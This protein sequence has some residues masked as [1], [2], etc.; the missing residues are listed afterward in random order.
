MSFHGD[1]VLGFPAGSTR[2]YVGRLA[3]RL[4]RIGGRR[5]VTGFD[6]IVVGLGAMGSA[7]AYQLAAGGRSV[8]GI[9]QFGPAHDRGSSHGKSRIIRQA[10]FEDPAYVPLL[11][12][13]YELWDRLERESGTH[14]LTMTGGLMLGPPEGDVVAGSVRS[15]GEHN[16]PHEVLDAAEIHR[17]FP[18]LTP[19]ADEMGLHEERAG[20]LDPEG[21]ISAHLDRAAQLGAELRFNE[22]VSDW[23]A[24]DAGVRV[25][26]PVDVYQGGALVISP[27]AWGPVLLRDLQLPLLIERQVMYWFDPVGGT[28]RFEVGRFPV[29]IWETAGGTQFYGFPAHDGPTGGAKVAVLRLEGSETTPETIDRSIHEEEVDRM[30]D[31]VRGRV[32]AL[33]A[34]LL[35]AKTCMYTTTPDEHFVI[36]LHPAHPQVAFAAGFSGHGYKFASVVGEILAELAI[37]GRTRH[38][39]EL[40]APDRF[41]EPL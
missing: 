24:T 23:Q 31:L 2:R 22:P 15:A 20:F 14:L 27:G 32:D 13:S 40:F 1:S 35:A 41:A 34:P 17:R 36:G 39:I 29:Y 33:D 8:L 37:D 26:T 5:P 28:A 21:C 19:G 3:A 4:P 11:D 30:R 7:A 25:T 38:D 18:P 6:V 10:Y 9:E 12:R 16:L